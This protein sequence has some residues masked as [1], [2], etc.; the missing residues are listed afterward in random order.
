MLTAKEG[1]FVYLVSE[2]KAGACLSCNCCQ[3]GAI[4]LS[5][6]FPMQLGETVTKQQP[7]PSPERSPMIDVR[8]FLL[9]LLLTEWA[10]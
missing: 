7:V 8:T 10:Q 3:V 1:L 2:T 9:P 5:E 6:R 4:L